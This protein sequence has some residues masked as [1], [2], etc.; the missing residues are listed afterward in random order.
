MEKWAGGSLEPEGNRFIFK[1]KVLPLRLA[2]KDGVRSSAESENAISDRSV[3]RARGDERGK[4]LGAER[5]STRA[6]LHASCNSARP[7]SFMQT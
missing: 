7:S 2:K 3:F 4:F 5:I 6:E 1:E